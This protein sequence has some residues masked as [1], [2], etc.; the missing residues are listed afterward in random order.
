MSA[1]SLCSVSCA[2]IALKQIKHELLAP[3]RGSGQ[4]Q[5]EEMRGNGN[6]PP[7]SVNQKRN[8]C[9]GLKDEKNTKEEIYFEVVCR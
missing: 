9:C 3:S 7:S 4:Y 6:K 2:K 1:E 8:K 5:L